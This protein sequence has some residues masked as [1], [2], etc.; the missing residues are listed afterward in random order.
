MSKIKK[1]E[2]FTE[3]EITKL[4]EKELVKIINNTYTEL[5]LKELHKAEKDRIQK[6]I[7]SKKIQQLLDSWSKKNGQKYQDQWNYTAAF[8]GNS[9][10][11]G[12]LTGN[13]NFLKILETSKKFIDKNK[14][15]EF[16]YKKYQEKI[17]SVYP[18]KDI[19]SV[20]KA[21]N[22]SVKLG[23]INYKYSGYHPLLPDFLDSVDREDRNDILSQIVFD[24][25]SFSK[26]MT[27]NNGKNELDKNKNEVKFFYNT[28]KKLKKLTKNDI[29]AMMRIMDVTEY[30]KKSIKRN[31]I[32]KL[33][34]KVEKEICIISKKDK[35]SHLGTWTEKKYNQI[36]Y[37][38]GLLKHMGRRIH[39]KDGIFYAKKLSIPCTEKKK[40]NRKRI[41]EVDTI[42]KKCLKIETENKCMVTNK[43]HCIN[44]HIYRYEWCVDKQTNDIWEQAYDPDNGLYISK[45]VDIRF[46]NGEITFN[47]ESGEIVFSEGYD[48]I[49][50]FQMRDYKINEKYLNSRRKEFLKLHKK[51][52][53]EKGK[54]PNKP[55]STPRFP[56][57]ITEKC[58]HCDSLHIKK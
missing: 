13:G 56:K 57:K 28:L 46:N 3:Q 40:N 54:R 11:D 35:F 32:N 44:S 5:Q 6:N 48:F 17:K 10:E 24:N 23:F 18:V 36:G 50:K 14:E 42:M 52:V 1:I 7:I 58:K 2:E 55:Q 26:N 4:T 27:K 34:K 53:F 8:S 45:D 33:L 47:H 37:V 16:D 43:Q 38:I 22:Q 12:G 31:E 30:E 29:I 21:I 9:E 41:G 39:E 15:K 20:R 25:S 49:E 19:A 51:Y